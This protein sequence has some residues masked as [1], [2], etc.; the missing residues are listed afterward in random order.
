V[1][2]KNLLD[3]T[4][5]I[6][7]ALFDYRILSAACPTGIHIRLTYTVRPKAILS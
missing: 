6:W 2:Q 4:D 1:Q 7:F 3:P 5:A